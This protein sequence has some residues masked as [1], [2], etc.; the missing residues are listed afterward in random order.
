MAKSKSKMAQP[1]PSRREVC[2]HKADI[3]RDSG[4]ME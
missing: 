2:R 4:I 3:C 1:P